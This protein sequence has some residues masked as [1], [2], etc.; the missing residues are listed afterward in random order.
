[1]ISPCVFYHE[2]RICRNINQSGIT[3]AVSLRIFNGKS[4]TTQ[5]LIKGENNKVAGGELIA[6]TTLNSHNPPI[7]YQAQP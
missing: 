4:L 6:D 5:S 3:K 7:Y 1:M 2:Q